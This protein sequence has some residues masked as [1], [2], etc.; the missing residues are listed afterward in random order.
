MRF[1]RG[2]ALS[3]AVFLV[4]TSIISVVSCGMSISKNLILEEADGVPIGRMDTDVF[5]ITDNP[6]DKPDIPSGPSEGKVGTEYTYYTTNPVNPSGD[7]TYY[8]WDWG[9]GSFTDWLPY[10][11][12]ETVTSSHTWSEKGIYQ[13]RVKAKND[14]GESPWSDPLTVMIVKEKSI[15]LDIFYKSIFNNLF[16]FPISNILHL[17]L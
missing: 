17:L 15:S 8:K 13:V 3:F 16:S 2:L 9:D 11:S 1:K 14:F 4:I 6:P 5:L 7:I 12:G 10:D